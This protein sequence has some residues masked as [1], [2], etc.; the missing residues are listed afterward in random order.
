MLY[1]VQMTKSGH[2]VINCILFLFYL[3]LGYVDDLLAELNRRADEGDK[4]QPEAESRI[5]SPPP[6]LS[7]SCEGPTLED[8]I[9]KHYTRFNTQ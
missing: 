3:F 8:A 4:T 6:A 2:T 7:S 1:L 5:S 9:K